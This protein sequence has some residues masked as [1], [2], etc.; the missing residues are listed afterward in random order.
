MC[1]C[2]VAA[3]NQNING[4]YTGA[5]TT[6]DDMF[7]D[8]AAF[9]QNI[10]GWATGAVTAMDSMFSKRRPSTRTSTAGPPAP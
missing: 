1:P 8:A 6:M 2:A 7:Y 9:N 3:F 4:W 10:N 5:V